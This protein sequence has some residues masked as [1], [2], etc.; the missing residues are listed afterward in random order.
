MRDSLPRKKKKT[1]EYNS[2]H[3]DKTEE[4]ERITTVCLQREGQKRR[5]HRYK[6]SAGL[7]YLQTM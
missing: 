6:N 7:P 3:T 1:R 4:G 2:V 5:P